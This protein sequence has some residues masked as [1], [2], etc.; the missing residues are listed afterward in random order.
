MTRGPRP[1][2]D[3]LRLLYE[4]D[5]REANRF[6]YALLAFDLV[7]IAYVIAT[8]FTQHGPIVEVVDVIFGVVI[9]A[10][11]AAR[12]AIAP[13]KL[14]YLTYPTTL[15]DMVAIASFLAPVSG[16]GLGFLRILRTLRL[17]H[18]YQILTAAAADSAFFRRN[19]EVVD[20]DGQSRGLPVR[21]DRAH[22][23]DPVPDEPGDR[24]LCRRALFHRHH[25]DDDGIWRHHAFRGR[26]GGCCRS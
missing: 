2:L 13:R 20:R 21:D 19:E 23:R 9:L 5:S 3:R 18:T 16:E 24:E 17:L 15:A 7:T 10:D 4:G 8:S 6:R 26:R 1:L 22:L 11:F 25:S 14:R 12:V